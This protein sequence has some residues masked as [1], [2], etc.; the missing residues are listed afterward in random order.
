[1]SFAYA[2]PGLCGIL[3]RICLICRYMQASAGQHLPVLHCTYLCFLVFALSLLSCSAER[4]EAVGGRSS[5]HCFP[6][7]G[8]SVA[9]Q[10]EAA[11]NYMLESVRKFV[12]SVIR[13]PQHITN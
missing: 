12:G 11:L 5:L 2:M 3:I 10:S 9:K 7:V 13:A 1:M 6:V 4:S 8:A